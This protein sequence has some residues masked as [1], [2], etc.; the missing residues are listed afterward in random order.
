MAASAKEQLAPTVSLV[1]DAIDPTS[2][3]TP[4]SEPTLGLPMG[5]ANA[6]ANGPT[7]NDGSCGAAFNGAVCGNWPR[8][9]CCSM[10]GY[11]G[12]R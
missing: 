10:Y 7:T 2:Q 9:P 5:A 12:N 11:C 3:A 6:S 1:I 8:G 4:G